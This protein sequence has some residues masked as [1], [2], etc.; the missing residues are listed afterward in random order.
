M[1]VISLCT[2]FG[3]ADPGVAAMKGVIAGI[4]PSAT[5]VDVTHDVPA[6]DIRRGAIELTRALPWFPVAIH[7]AVVD[8]GVG[9]TRREICVVCE[10]GDVLVGPDNGLLLPV[11]EFL[12]GAI[13]AYSL[14]DPAFRL[15]RVSRTFHGRDVFAPAAAHL[16]NGVE[17]A[18]FGPAVAL[19][20]LIR[21]PLPAPVARGDALQTAVLYIDTFG[22][23]KLAGLPDDLMRAIGPLDP[24]SPL[25]VE[26]GSQAVEMPWAATFADVPPGAPFI[27]GDED[28]RLS[29]SLNQESAAAAFGL[30]DD[31]PVVIRR[32]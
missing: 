19:D 2:D 8:P 9:G 6:Y 17:P 18:R 11:A 10:R 15:P 30:E 12:G 24:L 3:S 13:E 26:A 1:T 29:I 4:A 5:V 25:L 22:N 32:R 28:G 7:I 31:V 20:D 21:L 27:Y 14:A 16:A 23:A